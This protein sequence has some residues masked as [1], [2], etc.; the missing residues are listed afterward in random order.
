[1]TIIFASE[2]LKN[3]VKANSSVFK[4]SKM[5]VHLIKKVILPEL[6]L[7]YC[8]S[9]KNK[10]NKN[11]SLLFHPNMEENKIASMLPYPMILVYI[12]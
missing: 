11:L 7:I 9:W 8:L 6:C 10:G 3:I 5:K 2:P 1:M 4:S 12:V